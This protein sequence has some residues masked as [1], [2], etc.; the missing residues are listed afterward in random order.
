MSSA[1]AI[2]DVDGTLTR[3]HAGDY[4]R[5]FLRHLATPIQRY[6]KLFTL[7]LRVP[8][9]IVL[10]RMDRGRFNKIFYSHYRG[11]P[12]E[13]VHQLAQSCFDEVLLP[14]LKQGMV[15]RAAWHRQQGHRILLVSGS[16]DFILA[17]L[18]R[19]LQAEAVL[20]PSMEQKDGFFL[21]KL[22]GKPVV[23]E[24]KAAM[25]LEY[26]QKHDV[27]LFKSFAYGDDL[28]DLPFLSLA[29]HPFVV[30]PGLRL[31]RIAKRN[32]W[33]VLPEFTRV[34]TSIPAS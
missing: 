2:F 4:Y 13:K 12:V 17:P 23:G 25:V 34:R 27:D 16:L 20:C 30:H 1:A 8:Y 33:E 22:E 32:G 6:F 19:R 7:Y 31:L 26:A 18:A 5:F 14:C 10:D 28:S 9:W 24:V 21:G 11:F 29:G 15:E 3:S